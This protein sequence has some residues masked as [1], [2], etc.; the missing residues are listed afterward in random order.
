MPQHSVL[1]D[2][3]ET[4]R[5]LPYNR[6]NVIL[7][8]YE[9]LHKNG[10]GYEKTDASTVI[11]NMSV[12]GNLSRFSICVTEQEHGTELS[13]TMLQPCEGLSESGV[14]RAITAVADSISQYLE[15]E[16]VMNGIFMQNNRKQHDFRRTGEMK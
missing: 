9:V 11:S 16:L 2:G 4:K 14:Q 7:A 1:R 3:K 15:N 12:Y 5:T 6:Q 13:V 8:I 10:A